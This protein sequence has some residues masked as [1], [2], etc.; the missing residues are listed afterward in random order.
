MKKQIIIGII[1]LAGGLLPPQITQAQGT[2]YI[3]NLGQPSASSAPVGS[4]SWLAMSFATGINA[5]GYQLNS[6][7]L[8]MTNATGNPS[9]FTVMLYSAI[10]SGEAS[11]GSS[12]GTLNGSLNPVTGGIFT[13]SPASNLTLSPNT[14]YF[15]V[16]TAGTTVA[17]G[18]YEWSNTSFFPS[19]YNLRGGWQAPLGTIR[20]DNYQSSNGSSWGV[21]SSYPEFAVNATAVPEPGLCGLLGLGGLCF[22]WFHYSKRSLIA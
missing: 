19:T 16:L 14:P 1:V 12:L 13:Y 10:V 4:D 17:N 20:V 7:Q 22:F 5:G 21:F 3:S 8:G 18:A 15:I 11:P 6:I 2:A 9:G